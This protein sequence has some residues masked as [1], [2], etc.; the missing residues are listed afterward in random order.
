M[1]SVVSRKN[2]SAVRN[3]AA[4][5]A[6][7][8]V[9]LVFQAVLGDHASSATLLGG[10]PGGISDANWQALGC[11]FSVGLLVCSGFTGVGAVVGGI[12]VV[13]SCL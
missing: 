10:H 11:G 8:M 1:I 7:A 3:V 4:A 2:D 9:L 12:G 6:V 5:L 13:L